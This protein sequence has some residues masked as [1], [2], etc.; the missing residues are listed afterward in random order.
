MFKKPI[1][2]NKSNKKNNKKQ[3]CQKIIEL[4]VKNF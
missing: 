2:I 4:H 3:I 1:Y